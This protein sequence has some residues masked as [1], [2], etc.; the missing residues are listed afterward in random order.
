MTLIY[1]QID[2]FFFLNYSQRGLC[3]NPFG[4]ID[5]GI[6]SYLGGN[7]GYQKKKKASNVKFRPYD[8][9]TVLAMGQIN[10]G[11]NFMDF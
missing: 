10:S 11:C 9:F 4:W 5:N 3:L 6:T 1:C 2:F 7:E 8:L